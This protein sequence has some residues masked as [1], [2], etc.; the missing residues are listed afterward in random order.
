MAE[1]TYLEMTSRERATEG[2]LVIEV[3]GLEELQRALEGFGGDWSEV[4]SEALGIGLATLESAAKVNAPVDTGRLRSSIAS[5]IERTVGSEIVGKVGS[6]V[7][8]ASYQEYGTKY[9]SG[10]PYLRP[11][12]EQNLN[13]VVKQFEEGINRALAR[14]GLR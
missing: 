9:Q 14:L 8:Y 7:E 4:A 2:P 6:N 1:E 11:A 12:L 3:E 10:K 13:T 5:Q